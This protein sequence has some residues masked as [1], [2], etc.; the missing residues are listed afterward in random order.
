MKFKKS[1]DFAVKVAV[2]NSECY[3]FKKAVAV[4][5]YNA[6]EVASGGVGAATFE[7]AGAHI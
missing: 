3:V 4:A 5:L 7:R 2:A 6:H 1:D